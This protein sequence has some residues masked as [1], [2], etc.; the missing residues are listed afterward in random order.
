MQIV[1]LGTGRCGTTSLAT[2]ISRQPGWNC[3]HERKPFLSWEREPHWD[4]HFIDR[5]TNYADVGF[6]YLPY[7]E[8]LLVRYPEMQFLCLQRDRADTIASF[9][10]VRPPGTN[11]FS[12]TPDALN[13]WDRAFPKFNCVRFPEAVGKYWDAYYACAAQF[14]EEYPDRFRIIA[15]ED[16]NDPA[17]VE[18][19][20]RFAGIDAPNVVT[21]LRCNRS[22]ARAAACHC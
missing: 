7:V 11:W 5:R 8:K 13:Q 9:C 12:S 19:M 6:Y 3:A 10:R 16:L 1:G 18:Q 22:R 2:L 20:L 14:E 17:A 15:T 21:D 4:R